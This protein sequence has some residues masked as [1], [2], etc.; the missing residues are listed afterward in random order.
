MST[1]RS[2]G[3]DQLGPTPMRSHGGRWTHGGRW[4]LPAWPQTASRHIHALEAR[5]Q[6]A[7]QHSRK[8]PRVPSLPVITMPYAPEDT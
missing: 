3:L 6:M 2:A 1:R 4:G 8:P 7:R 5:S